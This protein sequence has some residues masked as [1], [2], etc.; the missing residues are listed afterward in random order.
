MFCRL[1]GKK[2][3]DNSRFCIFCGKESSGLKNE[4]HKSKLTEILLNFPYNNLAEL[5]NDIKSNKMVIRMRMDIA[6][7]W[8][9]GGVGSPS[10]E[11]N[12]SYVLAIVLYFIY[13]LFLLI[14]P[15]FIH[16]YWLLLLVIPYY[17]F[18]F[19]MTP[20]ARKSCI[21]FSLCIPI[22]L[23]LAFY[24]L[25]YA[26][27]KTLLLLIASLIIVPWVIYRYIYGVAIDCATRAILDD[28]DLFLAFAS[29]R[30]IML[31][32]LINK[33]ELWVEIKE[34]NALS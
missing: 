23:A 21:V 12:F 4:T 33:K 26:K 9:L 20:I 16:N 15:F 17:F 34:D 24:G 7:Q 5:K 32:D 31:D 28:E 6:R 3:D 25:F 14:I 29:V 2:I 11:R 10:W 30:A 18:V 22:S 8:L 19:I 1:C 13:P 27:D